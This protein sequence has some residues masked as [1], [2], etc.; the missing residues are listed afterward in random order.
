MR[1]DTNSRIRETAIGGV[2]AE[3]PGARAASQ[4]AGRAQLPEDTA[5]LSG[6]QLRVQSLAGQVKGLPD[7]RQQKVDALSLAIRQGRYDVTPEQ[8][9]EALL[10]EFRDRFAA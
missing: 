5:E 2:Q 9:A 1:I 3:Q 7:V 10:A 4:V 8:T 6:D